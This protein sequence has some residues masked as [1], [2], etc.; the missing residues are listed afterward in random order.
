M[1]ARQNQASMSFLP[2]LLLLPL[3]GASPLL[4]GT[5]EGLEQELAEEVESLVQ[6]VERQ[7]KNIDSPPNGQ[8]GHYDS[9]TN[10]NEKFNTN[11]VCAELTKE[12][13]ESK[14]PECEAQ[15]TRRLEETWV[16]ADDKGWSD[17]SPRGCFPVTR[18]TPKKRT[19]DY[20]KCTGGHKD[21][22]GSHVKINCE[23]IASGT[24][25]VCVHR[26]DGLA[27]QMNMAE[28]STDFT[29][30]YDGQLTQGNFKHHSQNW[31]G[32]PDK[33]TDGKCLGC[34]PYVQG[35]L[36]AKEAGEGEGEE[37]AADE[38]ADGAEGAGEEKKEEGK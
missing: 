15:L 28:N 21:E 12:V 17:A 34:N 35:N 9:S 25:H 16:V 26:V 23:W 37:G 18:F 10:N 4:D 14:G 36:P 13:C 22:T 11:H 29:S 1:V 20:C 5:V 3:L 6:E 38:A 2:F 33:G 31:N 30:R 32:L 19:T 8:K 24:L 27:V 7:T